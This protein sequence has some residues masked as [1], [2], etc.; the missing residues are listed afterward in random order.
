MNWYTALSPNEE[1]IGGAERAAIRQIAHEVLKTFKPGYAKHGRQDVLMIAGM[2]V[3]VKLSL[4]R[5]CECG[6]GKKIQALPR[7]G[8]PLGTPELIAA[9]ES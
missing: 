1:F 3:A 9:L 5:R 2:S 4:E 6:S 7:E 8:A